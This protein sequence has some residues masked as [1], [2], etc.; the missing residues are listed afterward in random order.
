M[1]QKEDSDKKTAAGDASVAGLNDNLEFMGK[2][3]HVQTERIGFPNPHIVT[4]VF[5]SGRVLSSKKA[6]IPD[7]RKTE[8]LMREQ[9]LRT[10]REISDKQKRYLESRRSGEAQ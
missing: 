9:H 2:H 4:Q 10:M 8:E 1:A 6:E 7:S 3:L 5:C